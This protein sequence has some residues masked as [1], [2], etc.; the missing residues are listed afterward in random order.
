MKPLLV[1]MSC[2]LPVPAFT[3]PAFADIQVSK[4]Y[5]YAIIGGHTATELDRELTRKGPRSNETGMRHPG[6]TQ[7]R[8]GG[9]ISYSQSNGR[10]F[11][12]AARIRLAT[13]II[14]PRWK[15][16]KTANA[17]LGLLWDVLL[18]DIKRHEERHAEIARL[19][20]R[21]M[22]TAILAL[23]PQK[24]CTEMQAR[25]A[26]VT[27]AAIIAHDKDQIRFDR[28]EAAN[29][30]KRMARLLEY[31]QQQMHVKN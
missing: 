9:T 20:A 29:F 7:I 17:R 26:Q 28:I 19:H 27:D 10:C 23:S 18:A 22:E 12:S 5:S 11:A 2:L 1:A 31:R 30:E 6:L 15:N 16:R 13:K 21:N 14:L 4:T 24:T 3:G 8:F 25:V